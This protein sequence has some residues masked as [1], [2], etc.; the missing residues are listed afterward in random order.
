[1]RNYIFDLDGTLINS[2]KEVIECMYKAFVEADYPVDKS[3]LTS[4]LIGPPLKQI[5]SNI[6]PEL[7]DEGK[8]SEIMSNFRRIYDYDEN[9]ISEIYPRVYEV[10]SE[11]KQKGCRLF[12]AT[13]KP[14]EPTFRIVKQFKLDYFEDVYTID[15]FETPITKEE[16]IKDIISRYNL[17]KEE[18][19]MIGDALSDI[20]AAKNNGITAI[21]ALWGYGDNKQPLIDNADRVIDSI[22]EL[23][24]K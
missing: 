3:K 2:S 7:K 11:L 16:M 13:F 18:T 9:D 14:S 4:N 1:M 12:M 8:F 23:C 24:L 20:N 6:A 22:G 17:K 15:K 21:G 5:I 19:A 10:L